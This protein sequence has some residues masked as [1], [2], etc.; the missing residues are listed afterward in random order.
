M[1]Y[2]CI[3]CKAWVEPRE[4]PNREPE[5]DFTMD[6]ECP[7]CGGSLISEDDYDLAQYLDVQD[8]E[9]FVSFGGKLTDKR[10]KNDVQ[11]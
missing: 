1:D 5:G 2:Y 9:E 6:K 11:D 10:K 7:M 3:N 4:T 8:L